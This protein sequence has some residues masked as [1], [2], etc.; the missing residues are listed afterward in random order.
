MSLI[1]IVDDNLDVVDV[2]R[3]ILMLD[4]FDTIAALDG[5]T[6]LKKLEDFTPDLILLDIMMEPMD[7]WTTLTNIKNNPKTASIPVIMLTAKFLTNQERQLYGNLFKDY[8][9]KPIRRKEL[10]E[11]VQKTL[12]YSAS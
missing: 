5:T 11:I 6:C 1:F 3:Q 12:N 7:G 10:C 8:I 4:G 9:L 2:F